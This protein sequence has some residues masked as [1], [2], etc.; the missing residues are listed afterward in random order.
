MCEKDI[1]Q[2]VQSQNT[3]N[4]RQ[5]NSILQIN[6]ATWLERERDRESKS[7]SGV[8]GTAKAEAACILILKFDASRS[9]NSKIL[10]TLGAQSISCSFTVSLENKLL[11]A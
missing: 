7:P 5:T 11:N 1:S 8:A 2:T 6:I 10:K 9:S 4:I 3:Y